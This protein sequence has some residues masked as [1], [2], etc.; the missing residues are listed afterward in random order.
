MSGSEK[1]KNKT[2]VVRRGP[3]RRRTFPSNPPRARKLLVASLSLMT[4][5]NGQH[6]AHH[7]VFSA[8][9]NPYF[10]IPAAPQTVETTVV[11]TRRHGLDADKF[12]MFSIGWTRQG[13]CRDLDPF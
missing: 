10:E 7:T 1:N 9:C 5:L 13:F 8:A 11:R 3:P 2:V 6:L 12:P 4:L